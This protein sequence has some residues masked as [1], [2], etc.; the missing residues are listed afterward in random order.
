[1]SRRSATPR[2]SILAARRDIV[3]LA[4][5]TAGILPAFLPFPLFEI[6]NF[7]FEIISASGRR[8]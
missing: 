6:L 8:H 5:C 4:S 3:L 2:S 7:K 1:M